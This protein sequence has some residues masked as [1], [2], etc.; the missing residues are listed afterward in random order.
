MSPHLQAGITGVTGGRHAAADGLA[1]CT[2]CNTAL[3]QIDLPYMHK[4]LD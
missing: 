1:I 2:S 3:C 4:V